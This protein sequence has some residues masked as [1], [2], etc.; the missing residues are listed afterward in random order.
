MPLTMRR[1]MMVAD[2]WVR[3]RSV[4]VM[5][6]GVSARGGAVCV[7]VGVVPVFLGRVEM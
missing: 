1:V 2:G 5:P 3:R 4:L 7:Q 6:V